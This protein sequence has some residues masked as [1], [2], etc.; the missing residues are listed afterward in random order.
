L[1]QQSTDENE[2]KEGSVFEE[3]RD[4]ECDRRRKRESKRVLHPVLTVSESTLGTDTD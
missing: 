4:L 2:R 1:T 3:E